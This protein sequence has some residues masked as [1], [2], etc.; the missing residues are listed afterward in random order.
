MNELAA[1]MSFTL[2]NK[3]KSKAFIVTTVI[4]G[5]LIAVF[6]HLPLIIEAFSSEEPDRI[7]MTEDESG[8]AV[9]LKQYFEQQSNPAIEIVILPQQG[10]AA[11]DLAQA[12]EEIESGELKGYLQLSDDNR[13][14]EHAFPSF[15]FHSKGT[16]E[17][18]IRSSLERALQAIKMEQMVDEL[19]LSRQQIAALTSP[20]SIQNVQITSEAKEGRSETEVVIAYILVYAFLIILFMAVAMYGNMIASEVTAE[21]SSRVMEVLISTVS[22]VK[23]MFG[24]I[25]GTCILG[26]LQL[27]VFIIIALAGLSLPY[28]RAALSGLNLNL[29]DIPFSLFAYFVIFYLLGFFLYGTVFA[30]IGSIVSRTED[31]GQALMPITVLILAGF[32]IGLFGLNAPNAGWISA[33]SYFPFFTPLLMFMRIGMTEPPFW[34]IGLSIL[35]ML[36]S[37]LLMGWL[38]AKI[39]RTGVLM[40]GKR[41]RWN[42]LWKAMRSTQ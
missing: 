41:P 27:A 6:V 5:L 17:F 4:I 29:S 30:A 16:M 40:Y 35:I 13:Q 37:I 15:V 19:G 33:V 2:K 38:A 34:Q 28:N 8:L 11:A 12:R 3:L 42:E 14:E 9:Q 23:Q 22:P 32:Y 7:G 20:V 31:L 24:K 26:M 18:S 1:V 36:A 10:T 39:Y 25:F 21:K